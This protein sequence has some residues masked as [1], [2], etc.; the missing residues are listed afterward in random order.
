MEV[1]QDAG[2]RRPSARLEAFVRELDALRDEVEAQVGPEDLAHL[3]K[4]E[5]WG[6]TATA[7]GYATAWI[8]PNPLSAAAIALGSSVRWTIVAHHVSHKAFDKIPGVPAR[9]T[10]RGFAKGRRRL[11][12]WFD[13]MWPEAWHHEHDVLH[14]FHTGELADPDLVEENLKTIREAELP[15]AVKYAV[16]IFY[17]S[18]WKWT[19]Y[20][21][22]TFQILKRAE[23]RWASRAREGTEEARGEASYLAAYDFRTAEG[24]EFWRKCV[25]PYGLGRFVALPLAFAPLGPFA[26]A[27]VWA[28]SLLAEWLTNL[29][30]FLI[31]APNHA[32]DDVQRFDSLERGRAGL[33]FRQVAGSVDYQT[34]TDLG[35]FFQ[36]FLNY[37]IEH[38]LF[39]TL[40]PL[41]Y[42]QIQPRVKAICEKHGIPYVQEPLHQRIRQL[43]GIMVGDRLMLR[44]DSGAAALMPAVGAEPVA[45]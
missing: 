43:V 29:H 21:P 13:W 30:T 37:Q 12:D 27:S 38:H 39:P 3:R 32:G 25:L 19:Y 24:R 26:V 11:L 41:R 2:P 14:H 7:L 22:N 5:R 15:K 4:F 16:V 35:D 8:A 33:Y 34:G 20:A 45:P 28:N 10:S 31:I 1:T 17:A 40:S 6:R 9:Y 36:G 44:G 23:R 42:Q 18:T